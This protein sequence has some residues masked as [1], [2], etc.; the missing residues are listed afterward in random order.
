MNS[1]NP[2]ADSTLADARAW[3]GRGDTG[4]SASSVSLGHVG[5][6]NRDVFERQSTA[7]EERLPFGVRDRWR[8]LSRALMALAP[9]TSRSVGSNAM[10][11]F[12]PDGV[13]RRQVFA[14]QARKDGTLVVCAT[15]VLAEACQAGLLTAPQPGAGEAAAN[16]YGVGPQEWL[17]IDPVT[18]RT[19]DPQSLYRDMTGWNR[20]AICITLP[21]SATRGEYDAAEVL[22]AMS[23]TPWMRN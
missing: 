8:R 7:C 17:T 19:P 20:R 2:A 1:I 23:A 4:W 5:E 12:V 18:P 9:A 3:L 10:L 15:D 21:P 22:C 16:R 11:F 13:Y 6:K 14:L